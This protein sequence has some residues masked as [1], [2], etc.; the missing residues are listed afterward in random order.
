LIGRQ[1]NR[2][3]NANDGNHDHQFDQCKTLLHFLSHVQSP[4]SYKMY[5]PELRQLCHGHKAMSVPRIPLWPENT[6]FQAD[7]ADSCAKTDRML[8]GELTK[9]VG[10]G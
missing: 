8:A 6:Y 1:R 9:I 7:T 3:Q 4:F 2:R 5:N 10:F